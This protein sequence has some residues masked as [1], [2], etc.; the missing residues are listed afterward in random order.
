M[1]ILIWGSLIILY[2][3][4]ILSITRIIIIY[5]YV[6]TWLIKVVIIALSHVIGW[7]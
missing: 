3:V 7:I 2:S 1:L 4:R 5:E 6:F